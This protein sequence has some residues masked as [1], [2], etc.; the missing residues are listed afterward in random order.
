MTRLACAESA[1][2]PAIEVI[3]RAWE[4]GKGWKIL[5]WPTD[6]LAFFE[7]RAALGAE[8]A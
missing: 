5:H 7:L 1:R 8:K 2:V 6:T 4:M 3:V